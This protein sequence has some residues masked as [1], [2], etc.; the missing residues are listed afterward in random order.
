MHGEK[1]RPRGTLG[2][3]ALALALASGIAGCGGEAGTGDVKFTS[4]G[5]DY[6]EKQIPAADFADGWSIHYTKFLVVIGAIR[7]ADEADQLAGEMKGTKLV[8]HVSPGVKEIYTWKGLEAKAWTKVSYQIRPAASDTE[9]S[10]GATAD[11][12]A[13]MKTNNLSVYVE[14]EA[15]KGDAKKIYRWGFGVPTAYVDCKGDKD[16]KDTSGVIVTNG[17]V[18]TVE[19]TIHGDHLYYDDLQSPNAKRRFDA[20]AD[21]DKDM[22]GTITL[23]ELTAEKLVAIDPMKGAYGTGA[24]SDINDLGAY[25]RALSRTVGHFRGE[26]EC[27]ATAP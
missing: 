21:A 10:A 27:F 3:A 22:D 25:V 23:D 1:A 7:I 12:L 11:D 17:G 18:D 2:A 26:G 20:I 8:N 6:I 24:A 14:A 15:T 9:A 19:L 5:E 16:G 13:M 4:W